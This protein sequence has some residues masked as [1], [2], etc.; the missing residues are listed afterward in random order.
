MPPRRTRQKGKQPSP[1]PDDADFSDPPGAANPS[2]NTR[3][4][5]DRGSEDEHEHMDVD[6]DSDPSPSHSR[7][8]ATAT[9]AAAPGE[10]VKLAFPEKLI[11][12]GKSSTDTLLR[13]LQRLH[14][15]LASYDQDTFDA[16]SLQ[17]HSV[18]RDLIHSTVLLHKDRGIKA[19]AAC[20][21]AD[22]LR[23]TAPDAP[24]TGEELGDVF[25]FFFR[26]L[27][28]GL[29]STE[30]TY[31]N[32]Y[33]HLLESLSTV[34]SV[35]LVCDLDNA[36]EMMSDVFRDFFALVRRDFSQVG[37]TG[38]AAAMGGR[39]MEMFMGDILIALLDECQSVPSDVL[40]ILMSQFMDKNAVR[41]PV[42]IFFFSLILIYILW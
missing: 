28:N 25:A 23:L 1:P 5:D 12:S 31:F 37:G 27:V 40:E 24:Y 3:S 11:V 34:K 9:T 15:L 2:A 39:K 21:L 41:F 42:P 17:R 7:Q 38:A 16:S 13:K 33:F 26:Q 10:V 30:S 20:C 35:V 8:N 32:Q 6:L 29:K 36:E 22:V 14:A 18:K 19:Y 4:H